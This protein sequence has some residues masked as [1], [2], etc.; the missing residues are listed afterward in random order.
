M[1]QYSPNDMTITLSNPTYSIGFDFGDF[2]GNS[3]LTLSVA[4]GNGDSSTGTTVSN[5]YSFFGA[6]SDTAFNSFTLNASDNFI[7]MDNLS[8]E[9][10]PVPEPATMLLFGLGIIGLAGVSRKKQK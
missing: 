4:L 10:S 6:I 1:W 7:L 5:G 3:G 9:N 2:S 8:Y